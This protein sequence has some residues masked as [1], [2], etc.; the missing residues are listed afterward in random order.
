MPG[1]ADFCC[2][3]P[4]LRVAQALRIQCVGAARRTRGRAVIKREECMFNGKK[5]FGLATLACVSLAIA[6]SAPA[7]A[8]NRGAVQP[9]A[10]LP[11]GA[12]M[13]EGLTVGPDGKVY[14]PTFNPAGS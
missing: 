13:V 9:F 7:A 2:S 11:E 5:R 3:A 14:S 6:F 10:L 4:L 8:W 12:H 1:A